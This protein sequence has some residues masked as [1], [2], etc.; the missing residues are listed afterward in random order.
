[1][2]TNEKPYIEA[3]SARSSS[4]AS[5]VAPYSVRVPS[6]LNPSPMPFGDAPVSDCSSLMV[7][8]VGASRTAIRLIRAIGYTRE[9]DRNTTRAR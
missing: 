4:D 7:H 8:R 2:T 3:Y 6:R 9:V 1:L 5:F